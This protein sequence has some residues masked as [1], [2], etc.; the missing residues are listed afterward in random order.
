VTSP[1]MLLPSSLVSAVRRTV[2]LFSA[3]RREADLNDEIQA[4]LDTLTDD[5]VRRGL[6]LAAACAAA[7]REFGGV[8]QVKET[9]RDQRS[10]PFVETFAQDVRYALR[11]LRASPGFAA[12]A[13][14][15]LALGIGA[16]S[17]VF[18][19]VNAALM[20]DLPVKDPERLA[21]A[22]WRR[23][24]AGGGN[25]PT[26]GE[27]FSYPVF[28]E[29]VSR[30]RV[31]SDM[32]ASG[33][34]RPN[35]IKL[36]EETE[37]E[38]AADI[39]AGIVSA[40]YFSMLGV[41]AS[42]GRTFTADD[43]RVP[44]EGAFV[45][46]ADGFWNRRFGR[47]PSVPGRTMFLNNVPF[48]IIG[49]MPRGFFGDRVGASRDFWVP[50]LMQP[51]LAPASN[52]LERR[53]STWFRTIGRLKPGVTDGQARTE[54]T[55]LFRQSMAD[56]IASGSGTRVG[57]VN[58][59]DVQV[60]IERGSQALNTLRAR[61]EQPLMVLMGVVGLVLLI[62]CC[63]VANLLL[64]RASARRREIG[65]RLAMGSSRVRLVRQLMTESLLL[66]VTGGV[67]GLVLA[68]ATSEL[69]TRTLSIGVLDLRSDSRVL[70]FTLLASAATT[71]VF[72]LVPALQATK[73]DVAPTLQSSSTTLAGGR[74]R[75][76]LGRALV[77]AQVGLTLWVL[78]GAGLLV[79]SLQ[80]M[81]TLDI[82]IDR[83]R[84][85]TV[86]PLVDPGARA[87]VPSLRRLLSDRLTSVPGVDAVG[88][89]T[90]Y[91]L[92]LGSMNTAPVRVPDS[93][94]NPETDRDVRKDWISPEYFRIVG[95]SL[96]RGRAFQ[97]SDSARAPR[98]AIINET[99][100]RHYFGDRNPVGRLIYFPRIDEQNR[101]VPFA[102]DL[103]RED[104]TEIVGV[105]RDARDF[106]LR[107]PARKMAFLP[108][109]QR[110]ES[111]AVGFGNVAALGVIHLRVLGD[112]GDVAGQI[113]GLLKQVHP[114]LAVG[115][116]SML[117]A[118][119]ERTSMG[120]ELMMTRLVSFFGLLA[121]LLACVGLY[122]VMSYTVAR[123]TNEI[124][125]RMAL[126]AR[127]TDLAGMML[128]DTA[129]LVI[130]GVA[131]GIPAALASTRL[132]ESL[133][134]GLTPTDP[135]TI[136]GV[137]LVMLTV[138]GLAGLLPAWRAAQV[139]PMIALRHQ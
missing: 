4:H 92:F 80:Y 59:A 1:R 23:T 131:L 6:S 100:A 111:P 34:W 134:F 56:E 10:L 57:R 28:Q 61:V 3:R 94:V 33:N 117:D 52:Q 51:R 49:V 70:M 42:I 27:F 79:R 101:Y 62:A 86:T 44:G 126:G 75:Q 95:M 109:S 137:T 85:M 36:D 13:I 24:G 69:L 43:S 50:I 7:R 87:D 106:S 15:S 130:G 115:R 26:P 11:A 83:T 97:E 110:P 104:G 124:G 113:R 114:A 96:V 63:N 54:L 72:G 127:Q 39:D 21:T 45:V 46:L 64:A 123:R 14:L 78:I 88:F 139:D 30:Q 5:Y 18:S 2:A 132:I 47:D 138:G 125:I 22:S 8:D 40:N 55:A 58:P 16:N 35:R 71:L 98:V 29:L 66:A 60:E 99:T 90:G 37:D 38:S 65:I 93:A 67:A 105:V 25:V 122:G 128:R 91:G 20:K 17:A 133:L 112:P 107:Q 31:F 19:V 81:R 119:I 89:S 32:A 74:P 120:R 118:D 108:L 102:R 116:I 41:R 76:Y 48:T 136:G 129:G 53:T 77:V 84:V 103:A 82:G 121:L 73:V 68:Q 9:C 12:A 135:A